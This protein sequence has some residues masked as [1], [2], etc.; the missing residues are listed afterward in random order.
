MSRVETIKCRHCGSPMTIRK[1]VD[2]S[3]DNT[4]W[5]KHYRCK[6]DL[7]GYVEKTKEVPDVVLVPPSVPNPKAAKVPYS[8]HIKK[9]HESA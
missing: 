2:V 1:K 7:C 5:S 8:P 9:V 3:N 4:R 6:N